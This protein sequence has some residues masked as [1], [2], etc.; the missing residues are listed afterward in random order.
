MPPPASNTSPAPSGS[1]RARGR[2]IRDAQA[3]VLERAG[4]PR[5][6]GVEERQ[7]AAA[8][9]RAHQRELLVLRDHV[10]AQV[11]LEER[12]RCVA[13]SSTQKAT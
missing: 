7:L 1:E 2:E 10:H 12:Q 4:L 5:P 13:R 3:D 9:V 8:G 11:A 6:L